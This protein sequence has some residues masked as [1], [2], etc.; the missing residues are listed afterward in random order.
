[1]V[2]SSLTIIILR[3]KFSHDLTFIRRMYGAVNKIGFRFALWAIYLSFLA[4]A[5]ALFRH[6][7]SLRQGEFYSLIPYV[8]STIGIFPGRFL[9]RRFYYIFV[10]RFCNFHTLKYINSLFKRNR[11]AIKALN[12]GLFRPYIRYSV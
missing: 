11:S 1:M 8:T 10:N 6:R 3:T 7:A 12:I 2:H 4:L 5:S 9:I